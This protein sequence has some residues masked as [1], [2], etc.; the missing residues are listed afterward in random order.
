MG[1]KSIIKPKI[2]APINDFTTLRS[3]I[4]AGADEI[5]FGIRGFNMRATAKNFSITDVPKIVKICHKNHVKAFLALNV[6]IYN[7][8]SK[9]LKKILTKAKASGI[10]AVIA[11]DMA[12]V[13]ECLKQR[14]P[15]HLSTQNSISNY[16][17]L[18]FYKKII[19]NL[20]RVVLARECSLDDIKDMIKRI[21]KDRLGVEIETFI[22]G[23]MCVSISGR[24]MLSHHLFGKSANRGEC[25]QPC[26][27]NYKVYE[28][29]STDKMDRMDGRNE[30]E[31]GED[32]VIS[33]K[34]LC[35]L[36]FIEKLVDAGIDSFKIEGRN[37]SAEYVSTTVNAYRQIIDHYMAHGS[38][39]GLE[40]IR[41]KE[42]ERLRTVFNRGFSDGFYLGRPVAEW[43]SSRTG[44]QTHM[45]L[46][47]G[48][49]ANYYSKADAAEIQ[50][51]D[52]TISIGDNLMIQ[53]PTTGNY[54]FKVM[55]MKDDKGL[56]DKAKKGQVI[57]LKVGKKVR[58]ND[59]VYIVMKKTS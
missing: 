2:L 52:R 44:E 36:P 51:E 54:V 58:K 34:D 3:A 24:C 22:H 45:K 21:K 41:K 43:S 15:I 19:P 5:Y 32:A 13:Q 37:R 49:V 23:A 53:G 11:W 39:K 14:I 46:Y 18:K 33:P 35:T 47:A 20:T 12:V 7:P 29:R 30:F 42:L 59:Q 56:I 38:G 48:K 16:E 27:R 40:E 55:E 26:R 9:E 1:N 17:S 10:D 6:I 28:I 25:L 50:I 57:G 4:D 8:E 31:L